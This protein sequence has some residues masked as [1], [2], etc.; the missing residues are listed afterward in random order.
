MRLIEA[1]KSRL[2]EIQR[3]I[4]KA[5]LGQ[6][7]PHDAAHGFC[8]GRSIKTFA[9]PHVGK[10]AVLKIDL[11]DFFPSIS[12]A[13]SVCLSS[14]WLSRRCG[15]FAGWSSHQHHRRRMSGRVSRPNH[16]S[17]SGKPVGD[18]RGLICHKARQHHRHWQT[19][20]RIEWIAGCLVSHALSVRFTHG[21]PTILHFQVIISFAGC[22]TLSCSR[23]CHRHGGR[24]LSASSKDTDYA[25]GG[26]PAAWPALW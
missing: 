7:P 18:I 10:T 2:K 16:D 25:T 3:R 13:D 4:L 12:A 8:A 17:F 15:G 24:I 11:Q 22:K 21:M 9:T 26:P 19:C 23:V 1:P 20:A 14:G 5:I 6:I